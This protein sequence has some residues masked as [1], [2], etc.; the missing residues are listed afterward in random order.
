MRIKKLKFLFDN[1]MWYLIY[2][3][4]LIL[5][6]INWACAGT[7]SL[8]TIFNNAGLEIVSNNFIFTGLVDIFGANSSIL[9]IFT[10]NDLLMYFSYFIMCM[11]IHIFVDVLLFIPRYCHKLLD[12]EVSNNE[13][14]K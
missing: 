13:L 3:M 1:F 10:N 6:V 11:I 5:L 8:A 4:P 9:P 2:L 14:W 12:G 7:T